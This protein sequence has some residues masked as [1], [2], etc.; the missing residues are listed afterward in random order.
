MQKAHKV[1]QEREG[2]RHPLVH[3]GRLVANVYQKRR[4]LGMGL[5]ALQVG[6]CGGNGVQMR[7]GLIVP[8]PQM[9]GDVGVL[10]LGEAVPFGPQAP[11]TFTELRLRDK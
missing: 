8:A 11:G 10:D 3:V 5:Y 6:L 1:G 4:E 2:I 9:A 7:E